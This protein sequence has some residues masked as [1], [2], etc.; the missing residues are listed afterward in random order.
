M[1]YALTMALNTQRTPILRPEGSPYSHVGQSYAADLVALAS[2]GASLQLII[3]VVRAH[4]AR[5]QWDELVTL[6]VGRQRH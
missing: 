6:A 3:D 2:T 1:P 5:W 4:S